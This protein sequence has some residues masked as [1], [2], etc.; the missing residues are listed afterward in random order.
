MVSMY[1]GARASSPRARRR[2][3]ARA[4]SA[5]QSRSRSSTSAYS[6]RMRLLPGAFSTRPFSS[7]W[8]AAGRPSSRAKRARI[9]PL[10]LS[11][12]RLLAAF[13]RYSSR[14]SPSPRWRAHSAAS[15]QATRGQSPSRPAAVSS[16]SALSSSPSISRIKP[17]FR[18][19][20]ATPRRKR[21]VARTGSARFQARL[22][23]RVRIIRATA[24]RI[25]ASSAKPSV[26]SRR[27]WS[28][29]TSR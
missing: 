10:K 23:N 25:S 6:A 5:G 19:R 11:P 2:R 21:R 27:H 9:R 17:L 22:P 4:H 28:R 14:A 3:G 13:C 29:I 18:R 1:R 7:R 8:A 15:N 16:R 20:R 24:P 12:R 26:D